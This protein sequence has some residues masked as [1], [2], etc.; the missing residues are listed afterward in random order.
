[1]RLIEGLQGWGG[2]LKPSKPSSSVSAKRER[3]K[4]TTAFIFDHKVSTSTKHALVFHQRFDVT[5]LT[6]PLLV[7]DDLILMVL[8]R[9]PVIHGIPQKQMTAPPDVKREQSLICFFCLSFVLWCGECI[10]S[11]W[12]T[13]PGTRNYEPGSS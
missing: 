2:W 10:D 4:N 8:E 1:V 3:A 7:V 12:G 5:N 11:R 6:V 13:E 9:E